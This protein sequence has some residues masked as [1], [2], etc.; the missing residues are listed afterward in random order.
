[1]G[2]SAAAPRS[3][4]RRKPCGLSPRPHWQPVRV[5]FGGP[6][7]I[8]SDSWHTLAA[9]RRRDSEPRGR[10]CHDITGFR[11][12]LLKQSSSLSPGPVAPA[13][14]TSTGSRSMAV[15]LADRGN[16][17]PG[18]RVTGDSGSPG[19]CGQCHFAP[20]SAQ[21]PTVSVTV[22]VTERN[23]QGITATVQLGRG[24][25]TLTLMV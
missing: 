10:H 11:G 24:L 1:M 12:P 23:T 4:G 15:A 16:Q 25:A 14:L 7:I 17:C 6:A 5:A 21:R 13:S 3:L 9:A 19:G 22:A 20:L 18:P 2:P 8:I